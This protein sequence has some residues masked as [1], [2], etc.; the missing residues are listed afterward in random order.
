MDILKNATREQ[1]AALVTEQMENDASFR[2]RVIS[3][4]GASAEQE[5][6]A[7]KELVQTSIRQNTY[8]RS[9]DWRGCDR[10]CADMDS[11]LEKARLHLAREEYNAAIE[12]AQYILLVGIKLAS[13]ADSSSGA[14]SATMS[15]TFET[16]SDAVT[17]IT[18]GSFEAADR[19]TIFDELL[20]TAKNKAFDGWDEDRHELLRCAAR[21]CN[22][23]SAAKL[24]SYLD[25]LLARKN[26]NIYYLSQDKETR[27]EIVLAS[28]G[29]KAAREYLEQN[30]SID[31]LREI[32]VYDD[33]NDGRFAH[34]ERLCL[35]KTETEAPHSNGF[36]SKWNYILF[37]VYRDWNQPD[38]LI[39]QARRLVLLGD[40]EYYSILKALLQKSGAWQSAYPMLLAQI[41]SSLPDEKSMQVLAVENETALLMAKVREHPNAVFRYGELLSKEYPDEIFRLC[42]DVIRVQAHDAGDRK[43]YA[44]VCK[45][46]FALA[47]Y[48]GDKTANSLIGEL[49][50]YYVRRPAFLDELSKTEKRL[51]K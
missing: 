46:I 33:M 3:I 48:G 38:K 5:L 40:L 11:V 31:R 44:R 22:K 2:M 16:I 32:A 39:S 20:K 25:E 23:K 10:I 13:E 30:L 41:S 29:K 45:L 21:L 15:D 17:G 18:E 42:A 7:A 14:L 8:R 37:A 19:Q 35:E 47:S 4:F 9:I 51:A 12:I 49:R 34:A 26:G 6:D 1:L 43:A 50:L 24:T 28:D 27:Y 36:I